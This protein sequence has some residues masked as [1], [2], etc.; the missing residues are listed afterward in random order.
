MLFMS[1]LSVIVPV[2]NAEKYLE[3]CILSVTGEMTE[4]DELILINDGSADGSLDICKK[5]ESE[6]VKVIG[7]ENH[8]VSY[9]RNCGIAAA[10]GDYIMFVDADDYLLS[11]WHKAAE[12]G[13][14]SGADIVYFSDADSSLPKITDIIENIIC[15]PSEKSLKIKAS[16]C[17]YKLFR[18]S[19]IKEQNILFDCD[20]INGEDGIFNLNAVLKC[21]S[22]T[23]IPT[24][25]F[26]FYRPNGAS[27]THTFNERFYTSNFKYIQDVGDYLK[28]SALF[29]D[30]KIKIY[31]DYINSHGLYVLAGR[32]ASIKD[33][34]QRQDKY[35][36]FST[37]DYEK[38]YREYVP[39]KYCSPR[40]KKVFKLLKRGKYDRA[41][42]TVIFYNKLY[43]IARKVLKK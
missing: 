36:L 12:S 16:A 17:W 37:P 39:D 14:E 33:R 26:Y 20:I 18:T 9:T 13:T 24:E 40:T 41:V 32:I 29:T 22:Y 28:E 11:G 6:N 1:S 21:K 43:E 2:Y 19:F 7:N 42:K 30:E 27:A 3:E 10:S 38:L 15:F 8:G 35:R 25:N 23:Q 5:Y 4:N 31:T 34:K